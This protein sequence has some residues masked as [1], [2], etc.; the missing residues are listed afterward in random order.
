MEEIKRINFL[1]II[2]ENEWADHAIFSNEEWSES[3]SRAE[4][5]GAGPGKQ[6]S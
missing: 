3:K 1:F 6:E 2:V 4:Q 5:T